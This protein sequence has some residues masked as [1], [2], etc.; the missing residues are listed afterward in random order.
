MTD[1]SA[2]RY[3]LGATWLNLL[4]TVGR[5]GTSQE[6]ERLKRP[7]LLVQWL[8]HENLT[9]RAEVTE[10]DVAQAKL[11]RTA[12]RSL[13]LSTMDGRAADPQAIAT[14]N[15]FL[16]AEEPL[17][18]TGNLEVAPPSTVAAALASIAREAVMHLTG[19]EA[20]KLHICAAEECTS[21]FL[22][23]SGRRRWCSPGSCG[24]TERVRAHRARRTSP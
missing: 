20:V 6:V 8:A 9:P 2:L 10:A 13:M 14:L 16:A 17:R 19:P 15:D 22:D 3:D 5:A 11:L 7:D 18:L 21:P 12:L 4:G 1:P 23:T 24:V